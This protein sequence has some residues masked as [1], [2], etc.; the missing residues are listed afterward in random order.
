MKKIYIL[1]NLFTTANMFCG[2]FAVV[3]AING[4]FISAAWAILAGMIFDSMDGRVARLTRATSAFGVEY[5]SFSDLIS[6]GIAPALVAY[7]WC[8]VPFE[9]LG[10][11]A[12][13]VYVACAALRL[14][15]F[16]VNTGVVPKRYFQGMP[17]PLAACTIATFIIFYHELNLDFR[18]DGV[19][20]G[21]L[22][23]LGSFMISTLRFPSFKEFKVKK[24]NAFGV[25]AL[26][27]MS[28]V[29]IAV[30]PE[31]TLF[32]MCIGYITC[33]VLYELYRV[34]FRKKDVPAAQ[35]STNPVTP[36]GN[37]PH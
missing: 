2:F 15:R 18:K 34:S 4:N 7:L 16:N 23:V 9:R 3:T 8:L 35:A 28:L 29:L 31:V 1:P 33:S 25:L 12:A 22:L 21:F 6:F 11:L 37:T 5:D 13:F 14:S 32:L 36:N 27:V 24:E 19:I 20:M 30:R 10:W 26:V 17:S